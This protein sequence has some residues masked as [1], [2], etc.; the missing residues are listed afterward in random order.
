VIHVT[1]ELLS[2]PTAALAREQRELVRRL[3]LLVAW[4]PTARAWLITTSL[5]RL[6]RHGPMRV[7]AALVDAATGVVNESFT[8]DLRPGAMAEVAR[9]AAAKFLPKLAV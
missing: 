1:G 4:P 2:P 6:C 7:N 9:A 8:A 3:G 5:R